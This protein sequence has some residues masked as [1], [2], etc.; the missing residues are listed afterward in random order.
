MREIKFRVWDRKTKSM[1]PVTELRFSKIDQSLVWIEGVDIYHKDSSHDGNVCCGGNADRLTGTPPVKRYELMQYT[2]LKDK[3][4][5]EIY[6]GDICVCRRKEIDDTPFVIVWYSNGWWWQE[7]NGKM[8]Y[9][10]QHIASYTEVIGNKW[11][12]PDLLTEVSK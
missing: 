5:V 8:D 10:P 3:S 11:D 4:G 9:F 1:F 6:E 12:N 7:G 2:G